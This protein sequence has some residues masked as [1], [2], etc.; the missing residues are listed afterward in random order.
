MKRLHMPLSAL[1]A[2]EAAARHESFARAAEELAITQPAVS[3]Q[4]A[5]LEERLG[6]KLFERAHRSVRLTPGG[7]RFAAR[8]TDA[9]DRLADAIDDACAQSGDRRTLTIAVESD[10]ARLW[11]LPRLHDFE[12][13]HPELSVTVLAQID[14]HSLDHAISDCAVVW[15]DSRCVD[16][17]CEPLFDNAAFPVCTPEFA[18]QLR[19]DP[20]RLRDMRLIHDRTTDWWQ[21]AAT[22]LDMPDLDWTSGPVY[23]QTTLCLEAALNG[24]GITIGDEVSSRH[25]L[26]EGLLEI[27]FDITLPSSANYYMLWKSNDDPGV[28]AF[29]KWIF[30]RADEHRRWMEHYLDRIVRR[31]RVAS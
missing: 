20:G 28:A 13:R 17:A 24:D 4:I 23:N 26:E 3:K 9:F 12:D 27:P 21:R 2:F 25:Y 6:L 29:H 14:P 19:A 8:L 10:F 1:R 16:C 18:R 5:A 15:G 22:K 30:A 31:A 7:Q 11:L